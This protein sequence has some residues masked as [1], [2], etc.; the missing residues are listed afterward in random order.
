MSRWCYEPV[1][2]M[3]NGEPPPEKALD[4]CAPGATVSC[5]RVDCFVGA[6]SVGDAVSFGGAVLSGGTTTVIVALV[7]VAFGSMTKSVDVDFE[8]PVLDAEGDGVDVV[9]A[10]EF[11]ELVVSARVVLLATVDIV[12][13][14]ITLP[15]PMVVTTTPGHRLGM[16]RSFWKTPM[17]LSSPTS[18]SA[19]LRFTLS[20]IWAR[21]RTHAAEHVA[22]CL[23]SSGV[24]P[25]MAV[26]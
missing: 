13:L 1:A 8:P 17:M 24:H 5:G 22:P 11:V 9:L 15:E 12:V 16:P 7:A 4:S 19:Q 18:T 14:V 10:A 26:V 20:P 23:K 25:V 2:T 3:S 6:R 21:P